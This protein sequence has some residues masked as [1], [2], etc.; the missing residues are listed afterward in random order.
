MGITQY[1]QPLL[2]QQAVVVVL[3]Q[4]LKTEEQV[5]LVVV[6]QV[7]ITL[8]EQAVLVIAVLIHQ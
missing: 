5:V 6:D 2:Q 7:G 1:F 4:L 3:L 8:V